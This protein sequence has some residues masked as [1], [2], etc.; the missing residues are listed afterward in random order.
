M[1]R[2][3]SEAK[4]RPSPPAR[5]PEGR[6][7]QLISMAEDLAERQLAEGTA[8]SQVIVHFLKLATKRER[9]EQEMLEKRNELI[10]AKTESLQAAKR[11]EELY[12]NALKAM[13]EYSGGGTDPDEEE[14]PR[15]Y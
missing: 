15:A 7:S 8:S 1:P 10:Q 11:I 6:E 2:K 14:L 5:T 12:E 3:K 4:R 13:K 9:L